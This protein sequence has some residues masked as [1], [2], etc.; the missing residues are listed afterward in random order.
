[1]C[2]HPATTRTNLIVLTNVKSYNNF[3][4]NHNS[5][6]LCIFEMIKFV[7]IILAV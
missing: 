2:N 3:I 7:A 6:M 4:L 1:M 5:F